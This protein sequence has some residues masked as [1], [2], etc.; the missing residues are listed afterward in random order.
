MTS[1]HFTFNGVVPS[2]EEL[3]EE[4]FEDYV[5]DPHRDFDA[6]LSTLEAITVKKFEATWKAFL[7]ENPHLI[8]QGKKSARKAMLQKQV[9]D[10]IAS[11]E[12]AER[13]LQRQ[14]E[15]FNES[16]QALEETYASE[17]E[18]A[19][20]LQRVIHERLDKQLGDVAR[21]H[22]LMNETLPWE[23]FLDT[24]DMKAIPCASP[25]SIGVGN[26]RPS[27]RALALIDPE[28]DSRDIQL[29]A[30]RMDHALLSSEIKMLEKE[31]ERLELTN[32]NLEFIGRFLT[33]FNIW[34]ILTSDGDEEWQG[35]SRTGKSAEKAG[36]S[37]NR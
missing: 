32:Q 2:E 8:P 31:T 17:V 22:Q 20:N 23:H 21:S 10:T 29:R 26:V 14:V 19:N 16:R 27:M 24:V 12:R 35:D 18:Y 7:R 36:V 15:F 11:Q 1:R 5:V 9:A 3:E 13:E 6:E 33:E 34:G 25:S 30:L 28:G 4:H 37:L